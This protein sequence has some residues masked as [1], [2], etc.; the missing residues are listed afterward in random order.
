MTNR[1]DDQQVST[2]GQKRHSCCSRIQ[3]H[4]DRKR[5]RSLWTQIFLTDI[6]LV[7][8]CKIHKVLWRDIKFSFLNCIEQS[9][10]EF[11]SISCMSTRVSPV[12]FGAQCKGFALFPV[13]KKTPTLANNAFY[14]Y[15][16][17]KFLLPST[18]NV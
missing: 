17:C 15:F 16:I 13:S 18:I 7:H 8:C 2:H 3:N 1:D 11:E 14:N 4:I 10:N 5:N 6:A 9:N 12:P